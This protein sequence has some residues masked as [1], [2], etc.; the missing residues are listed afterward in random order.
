[1]PI[2]LN[3]DLA[4]IQDPIRLHTSKDLAEITELAQD[5]KLWMGLTSRIEKA[6]KV[7]QTKKWDSKRH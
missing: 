2:V 7:S 4:P 3:R 5:W 1:M 6:A